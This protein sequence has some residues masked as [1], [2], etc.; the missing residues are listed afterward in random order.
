MESDA[1]P[2]LLVSEFATRRQRKFA[3]MQARTCASA[4]ESLGPRSL[5]FYAVYERLEVNC[6][7]KSHAH[8]QQ[9]CGLW[10]GNYPLRYQQSVLA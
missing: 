7:A 10:G 5:T 1:V 8:K 6:L 3:R 4:A 9:A 2:A